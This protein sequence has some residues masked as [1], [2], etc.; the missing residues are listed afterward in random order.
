MLVTYF[1]VLK[2]NHV[3]LLKTKLLVAFF[4]FYLRI[5]LIGGSVVLWLYIIQT[6]SGA[7]LALV[8][9]WLFDTGFPGVA[10]FWWETYWGSFLGRVH[11]EFGNLLFFMIYI[12]ILGKIWVCAYQGETDHTW[13]TGIIILAFTYVAG[14]TGAIM[15]C[16][17]LGEVTATVIGYAINSLAFIK[18]DFLETF[19]LPGLGLTD[20]TLTRVF[21]IHAVF[22]ILSLLVAA[23]HINNLH[24]TEYTDEDEMLIIF[25]MRFEYWGEFVWCEFGFWFELLLVFLFFRFSADFF[26]PD[27]LTITYS[28]SNFE[29]WP[30]IEEIDFV[31]A[32]PHWYL[33]PLMSSL[34]LI[35]HHYLGFFYVILMFLT[36]FCLPWFEDNSGLLQVNS[37]SDYINLRV[38]TEKNITFI[39]LFFLFFLGLVFTCAIVPTGRYFVSIGS[40]EML[41]FIFWY[42]IS[43]LFCFLKLNYFIFSLLFYEYYKL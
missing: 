37:L 38:S 7:L 43:Y 35:P 1:S 28:L 39:F 6:L 29:Y 27:Y 33:R 16:S 41:I 34:V 42:I 22:P 19:M 20:D 10:Y 40:S 13:L 32:I 17:I 5:S 8:Y 36:L 12:H 23:D 24:C 25:L 3:E 2:M 30:I 31:L 11:S 15:P 21:I 4:P 18:F 9:S 14:I 26:W